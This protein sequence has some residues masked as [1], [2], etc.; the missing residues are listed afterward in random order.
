LSS[1]PAFRWIPECRETLRLIAPIVSKIES[2]IAD[3]TADE[4][5][6][7]D[8]VAEFL[9]QPDNH[10]DELAGIQSESPFLRFGEK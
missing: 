4:L 5:A 6:V 10:I 3:L 1:L 8:K 2:S 9:T 7:L